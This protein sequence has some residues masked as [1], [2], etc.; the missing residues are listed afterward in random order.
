MTTP[1]E[2]NINEAIDWLQKTGGALQDFATE[3]AP[4]Y[5]REVVA[6]EFWSHTIYAAACVIGLMLCVYAAY[7][8]ISEGVKQDAAEALPVAVVPAVASVFLACLLVGQ[9]SDAAKAHVAPRLVI[10]EHLRGLAK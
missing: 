3:Q 1:T 7:R 6:W 9:I 4:L 2:Q 8:I 5:C 10:V